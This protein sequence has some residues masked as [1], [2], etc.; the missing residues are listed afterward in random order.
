M[1][2]LL[3]N[4]DDAAVAM[5]RLADGSA[6]LRDNLDAI[7]EIEPDLGSPTFDASSIAPPTAGG[8]I[9]PGGSLKI[10]GGGG[11]SG[12]GVKY[13]GG[14][15]SPGRLGGSGGGAAGGITNP[16]GVTPA[17]LGYVSKDALFIAASVAAAVSK[18]VKEIAGDGG[19]GFRMGGGFG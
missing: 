11:A 18:A 19:A 6:R 13:G 1:A 10:G 16:H 8:G 4:L 3:K 5:D 15:P 14:G 9:T 17:M 12:A 7:S 2:G